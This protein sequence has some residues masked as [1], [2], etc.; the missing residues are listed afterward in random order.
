MK[1]IKTTYVLSLLAG[2]SATIAFAYLSINSYISLPYV[3]EVVGIATITPNILGMILAAIT[4]QKIT[5]K[6]GDTDPS[7]GEVKAPSFETK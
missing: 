6:K 4:G 1:K 3:R 5:I 2:F 7:D